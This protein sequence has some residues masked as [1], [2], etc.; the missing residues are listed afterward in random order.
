MMANDPVKLVAQGRMS[1]IQIATVAI[2]TGLNALDGF[3]V[4]AI[5]FA[6]PSIAREW[7][8][9]PTA[10]G[11]VLS[12]ELIGMVAGS[13][14]LGNLA[15]R[16]GRRPLILGCLVLMACEMALA[17]TSTGIA[18]LALWRVLTG[19]GIGGMLP[20]L[21]AVA[22]EVSNAR[23]RN[24]SVALMVV[25]YPI[26]A[27]VGGFLSAPLLSTGAWRDIFLYGAL[28][29]AVFVPLVLLLVPETPAFLVTRQPK[30]ALERIN[31]T[32]RRMQLPRVDALPLKPETQAG[33]GSARLLFRPPLLLPTLLAVLL[34]CGHITTFYFIMKWTTKLVVDMGYPSASAAGVLTWVNVGG[35]VACVLFGVLASKVDVRRLTMVMLTGSIIS[36]ACLGSIGGSLL[37]LTIGACVAGV[38]V[39]ASIS[40]MY[41]LMAQIFP[42]EVRSTGTGIVLGIGRGGGI[43]SPIFVGALLDINIA[44][45]VI[46]VIMAA[47]SLLALISAWLLG[48]HLAE[49]DGR[50]GEGL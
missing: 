32:L 28:I 50:V 36:V 12:M 23:Q 30:R 37:F 27:V 1:P 35:I 6:A 41:G 8:I 5:S 17:S 48:K 22:S 20:V 34:Y 2:T 40:G 39:N 47:G 29:T 45:S 4:L 26:G 18:Q 31:A 49:N 3:D 16:F 11:V 10:L 15:D 21:N 19:I 46:A 33:T 24:R 43:L 13:L 9:A 44:V 42:T 38:F 7:S 25:G 14:L